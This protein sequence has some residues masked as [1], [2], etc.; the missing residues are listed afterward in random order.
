MLRPLM[1]STL[2]LGALSLLVGQRLQQEPQ[3]QQAAHGMP[4]AS[5]GQIF[6]GY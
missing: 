5:V 1:I 6:S 4:A 2:F 3:A